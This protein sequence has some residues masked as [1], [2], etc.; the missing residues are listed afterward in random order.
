MRCG[1]CAR[2]CRR[3]DARKLFLGNAPGSHRPVRRNT[4]LACPQLPTAAIP[5][6]RTKPVP[7]DSAASPHAAAID[8][9][10]HSHVDA[11]TRSLAKE[12]GLRRIRINAINR[13]MV[14]TEGV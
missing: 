12:L 1:C 2:R 10:R 11:V 4:G 7:L 13:A 9:M 14:E 8:M 5:P 6:N 3:T